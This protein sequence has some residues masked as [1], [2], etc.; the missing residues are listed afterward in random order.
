MV[1]T[2]SRAFRLTERDIAMLESIATA[3]YLTAAALEWLH[4]PTWTTRWQA[5]QAAGTTASYRPAPHLYRRL[6]HLLDY[7]LVYRLRRPIERA[8]ETGS[9]A[10][11]RPSSPARCGPSGTLAAELAGCRPARISAGCLRLQ[12]ALGFFPGHRLAGCH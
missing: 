11:T 2:H 6:N 8:L 10:R 4:S 5:A 1:A 7:G 12:I 3:R 9:S